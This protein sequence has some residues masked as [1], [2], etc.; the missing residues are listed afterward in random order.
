MVDRTLGLTLDRTV[1]RIDT[2]GSSDAAL[3]LGAYRETPA[4]VLLGDP[5]AGKTTAFRREASGAGNAA[6][7]VT[8]RDFLTF[9][10]KSHPEWRKRTLFIDG[11]DEVRA[12]HADARTPLDEIRRRLDQLGRPPFRISCRDADWLGNNDVVRLRTVSP[13]GQLVALRLDPLSNEQVRLLI[14]SIVEGGNPAEFLLKTAD[15]GLE[16][17]LTN[18]Q[19][20]LL[21]A[22]VFLR[23]GDLPKSRLETFEQAT[24]LLAGEPNEEHRIAGSDLP[25]D[26]ILDA[27]GW[28][29]AVQLLSGADGHCL[30]DEEPRTAYVSVSVFEGERHRIAVAALRTRLFTGDRHTGYFRPTHANIAAFL[31]ARTIADLTKKGL[32]RKRILTLL[33]GE[34]GAPP[35]TL[36]ALAAWLAAISP[37]L[38]KDLT[39]RDPVAVLM[40]GDIREFTT[41]E[42]IFLLDQVARDPSRLYEGFWPASAIEGLAS[43]DMEAALRRILNDPDPRDSKQKVAEVVAEALLHTQPRGNLAPDLLAVVRDQTRRFQLRRAALDA[44][45]RS[46]FKEADGSN[47]LRDALDE[48]RI[49]QIRDKDGEL[50]GTL[51]TALYPRA[52]DASEVW[53]YLVRPSER[54]L[55]LYFRFWNSLSEDCPEDHLPV[56]L[57]CLSESI[58]RVR[59]LL[60]HSVVEDLPTRLLARALEVG[61][62]EVDPARL[63]RWL[64]V[65]LDEGGRLSSG[66][67][68]AIEAA[69]R[70]R[71]WLEARPGAQKA[72]IRAALR[73]VEI[74]K[75]ES[76]EYHLGELLYRSALPRD[77]G[78]WHLD[79]AIVAEDVHLAER[80]IRGYRIWPCSDVT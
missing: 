68:R 22:K 67:T 19:S 61:G 32:P 56:H 27:A 12:G 55:G 75:L 71:E 14:A 80:H 15:R 35:T 44:L 16:G 34:D 47:R 31:A 18:P 39:E 28:L 8:A 33:S 66:G 10:P 42:K 4:Y 37:T 38:R 29:C 60:R 25:V 3:A 36:R 54:L 43:E 51:L 69:D 1:R 48:I 30:A 49:G 52:L 20:L 77:I 7:F 73:T 63:V 6:L 46:V 74:R 17:M 41:E 62:L 59:D 58:S 72:I 57:D 13:N 5:G 64:R 45:I 21:L 23:T 70:V 79:E 50:L 24:A 40:Y 11:L 53:D 65:G 26:S 9:E 2:Q 76:A 78:A